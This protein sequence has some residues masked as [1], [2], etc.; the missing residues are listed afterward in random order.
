V[1]VSH[2]NNDDIKGAYHYGSLCINSFLML[3]TL[4]YHPISHTVMYAVVT[5]MKTM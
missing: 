2:D 1:C 5:L 4:L 3:G